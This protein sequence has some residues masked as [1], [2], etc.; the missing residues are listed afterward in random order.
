[1]RDRYYAISVDRKLVHP[2]VVAIR[3][4]AKGE[5]FGAR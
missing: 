4:G 1:V 2:A 5:L 3:D